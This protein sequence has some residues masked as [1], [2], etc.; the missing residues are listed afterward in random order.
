MK[1]ILRPLFVAC[2]LIVALGGHASEPADYVTLEY[3]VDDIRSLRLPAD[4][5]TTF[6]DFR[7]EL[8][9]RLKA[10]GIQLLA[11]PKAKFE[12][13]GAVVRITLSIDSVG[14]LAKA[15]NSHAS[16][17][18]IEV[19]FFLAAE[20]FQNG[21]RIRRVRYAS[22]PLYV[23]SWRN[24]QKELQFELE[25]IY[26]EE[27]AKAMDLG[28][29]G[30]TSL[31]EIIPNLEKNGNAAFKL[32]ILT[33]HNELFDHFG[34][35]SEIVLTQMEL[36]S[37]GGTRRTDGDITIERRWEM[38]V[39]RTLDFST[40]INEAVAEKIF[41][42]HRQNLPSQSNSV[43][44]ALKDFFTK[45][46]VV[47]DPSPDV[48]VVFTGDSI[49]IRARP[50]TLNRIRQI[51][52]RYDTPKLVELSSE[53]E[54]PSG[55]VGLFVATLSGRTALVNYIKNRKQGSSGDA[56]VGHE[57]ELEMTPS[58][59]EDK[60]IDFK[61]SFIIKDF[62]GAECLE[63]WTESSSYSGGSQDLA[64]VQCSKGIG[65][66]TNVRIRTGVELVTPAYE[67]F[68]RDPTSMRTEFYPISRRAI[69][70]LCDP[71]FTKNGSRDPFSP[72]DP[73]SPSMPSSAPD[74]LEKNCKQ[75]FID[76]GVAFPDEAALAFDGT[77]F[78]IAQ[79]AENHTKILAI[80]RKLEYPEVVSVSA[81]VNTESM[82]VEISLSSRAF[83]SAR[84]LLKGYP[85][86][87]PANGVQF[88]AI[89]SLH[90]ESG[91]TANSKLQVRDVN[92]AYFTLTT[93]QRD[94]RMETET[95]FIPASDS[96]EKSSFK[97]RVN[98]ER[99]PVEALLPAVETN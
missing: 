64:T 18:L 85:S 54:T 87:E 86:D 82:D 24:V 22:Q 70:K 41:K 72:V 94:D 20:T 76:Q 63:L 45:A 84:L 34:L 95:T 83:C 48:G 7:T 37:L 78:I 4:S 79:T 80:L 17:G 10:Q 55:S 43:G 90:D 50:E 71:A 88:E 32:E 42:E 56:I 16:T 57:L 58:V 31:L 30:F 15:L 68:G 1:I 14:E 81:S 38:R 97:T 35:R 93:V 46:G 99:L 3:S 69:E 26:T 96:N 12:L 39:L 11:D 74:D 77:Q 28:A 59:N 6:P 49:I 61:N 92:G 13:E 25:P 27:L 33:P 52:R 5:D 73:F 2:C 60:S 53:I 21:N 47:F 29:Q 67:R 8:L 75:A 91:P 23:Q 62:E 36:L 51:M 19:Q 66:P 89:P 9:A 65:V 40:K 44:D 98:T